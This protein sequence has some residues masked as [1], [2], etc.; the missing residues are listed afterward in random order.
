LIGAEPI[1]SERIDPFE[2]QGTPAIAAQ[3]AIRQPVNRIH[4][5]NERA[6]ALL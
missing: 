6:A 4:G 5:T 1:C 3:T 2:N